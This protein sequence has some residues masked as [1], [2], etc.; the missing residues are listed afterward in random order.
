MDAVAG[1]PAGLRTISSASSPR[2][3][4]YSDLI[5]GQTDERQ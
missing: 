2:S 1:S 4:S 5:I 3:W